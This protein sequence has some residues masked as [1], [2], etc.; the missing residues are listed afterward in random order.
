M[1]MAGLQISHSVEVL[2]I[3]LIIETQGTRL[4]V[5]FQ[6]GR[7]GAG[8]KTILAKKTCPIR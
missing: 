8:W 2:Q 4:S 6:Y 3:I 7:D 1:G 5:H